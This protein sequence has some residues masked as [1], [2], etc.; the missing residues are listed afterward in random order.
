MKVKLTTNCSKM[1]LA[2]IR[3]FVAEQ[4]KHLPLTQSETNQIILAV[5]EACAN[6]IIHG[7][8]CDAAQEILIEVETDQEHIK[9]DISDVGTSD[10]VADAITEDDIRVLIREQKKG[11]LGLKLIHSIMDEVTFAQQG[12]RHVCSLT[13]YLS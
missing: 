6:A 1:K 13:K 12:D 11:G 3:N 7:H 8:N 9:V 4:I 2:D 5:D 10:I